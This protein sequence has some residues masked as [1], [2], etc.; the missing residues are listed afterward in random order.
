MRISGTS[1]VWV[2]D[3]DRAGRVVSDQTVKTKCIIL[4]V[5]LR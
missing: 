5:Q 3:G 4:I 1:Q 2:G